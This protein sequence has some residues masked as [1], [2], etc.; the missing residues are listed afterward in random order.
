MRQLL[1]IV[2]P[3]QLPLVEPHA[4]FSLVDLLLGQLQFPRPLIELIGGL[5]GGPGLDEA[6]LLV[7]FLS[8]EALVE[9]LVRDDLVV[10]DEVEV[11]GLPFLAGGELEIQESG[12]LIFELDSHAPIPEVPHL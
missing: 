8:E 10:D 1:G 12:F 7:P 4:T 11:P 3:L 2:K 9:F 6:G 5:E